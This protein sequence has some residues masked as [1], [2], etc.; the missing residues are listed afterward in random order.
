M[1][2]DGFYNDAESIVE[3]SFS[4]VKDVIRCSSEDNGAGF[5]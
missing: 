5:T 1:A 2:L 3:T 4:L